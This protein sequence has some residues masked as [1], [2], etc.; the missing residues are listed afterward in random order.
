M[1]RRD[2]FLYRG[3]NVPSHAHPA[4]PQR[5]GDNDCLFAGFLRINVS[6]ARPPLP[7]PHDCRISHIL[8]LLGRSL[9]HPESRLGGR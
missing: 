1:E 7:I 8:Y 2:L 5:H 6:I 3:A 9:V 4:A